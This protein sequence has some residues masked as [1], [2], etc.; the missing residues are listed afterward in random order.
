[1]IV[2]GLI[3]KGSR[4]RLAGVGVKS[5]RRAATCQLLERSSPALRAAAPPGSTL[6]AVLLY[7]VSRR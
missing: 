2:C 7:N 5:P 4:A 6:A 3:T 1:M